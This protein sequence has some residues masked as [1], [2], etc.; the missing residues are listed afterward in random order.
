MRFSN[1][2]IP[3]YIVMP[4]V[5]FHGQMFANKAELTKAAQ[6]GDLVAFFE[7]LEKNP[8][9]TYNKQAL[10]ENSKG[11]VKAYL[12]GQFSSASVEDFKKKAR[13]RLA[14]KGAAK[15][16]VVAAKQ[17]KPKP[18]VATP[19]PVPHRPQ[20]PV[21]PVRQKPAPAVPFRPESSGKPPVAPIRVKKPAPDISD[22]GP[23]YSLSPAPIAQKTPPPVPPRPEPPVPP[24]RMQGPESKP[25]AKKPLPPLQELAK[26][27]VQAPPAA[28]VQAEQSPS[29]AHAA[30][31]GL[32][33]QIRQ[34]QQLRSTQPAPAQAPNVAPIHSQMQENIERAMR[35][36]RLRTAGEEEEGSSEFD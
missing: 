29:S 7:V 14:K 4:F 12:N 13:L 1:F 35:E 10:L 30:R 3:L 26:P 19:P 9:L 28:S 34:G 18:A 11:N 16:A 17:Q 31:A 2:T 8:N 20:P 27:V 5:F 6:K 36:R 21:P 15:P 23:G 24:I 25:S 33:Q 22:M 32:M